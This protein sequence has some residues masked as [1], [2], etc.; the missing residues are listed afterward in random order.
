MDMTATTWW[1]TGIC[2]SIA[3]VALIS[4]LVNRRDLRKP[5]ASLADI[6]SAHSSYKLSACL[7]WLSLGI[8]AGPLAMPN[9]PW[10]LGETTGP[11]VV[12]GILATCTI[13]LLVLLHGARRHTRE[14]TYWRTDERQLVAETEASLHDDPPSPA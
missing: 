14:A 7:L 4:L 13:A 6:H 1:W 12:L 8:A 10:F 9:S 11:L 5:D 3:L 2:G